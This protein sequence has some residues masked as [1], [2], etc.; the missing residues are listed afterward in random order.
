MHAAQFSARLVAWH[1]AEG[2]HSLP[3]QV[4]RTPYRVWVS[5]IML[6][7][8]QVATVI[9]YFERFMQCFPD[10]F[11]LAA[12]DVDEVLH[13]WSGL[14][15]YARGRNL[16]RAARMLVASHQGEFPED[17]EAVVALPGIGR[18]TAGAILALSRNARHP[19]LD[20]N[21]KRVLTR[22]FAVEGWP[23]S[24]AV[25]K[26]LWVL[27]ETLT[28]AAEAAVYTQAI[29][30][31]GA[32]LCTRGKP[33]CTRCPVA[34]SCLAKA[35]AR[36]GELP[37]PRPRKALPEKST[38][39]LVLSDGDG[40]WLLERRPPRGIWGG[41]WSFPELE[42][43]HEA[44][45]WARMQGLDL[46]GSLRALPPISHTFTHFRLH[47][48]PLQGVVQAS[49]RVLREDAGLCWYSPEA[50]VDIGLAA[51]VSRLLAALVSDGRQRGAPDLR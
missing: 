2:R 44:L 21:V 24:P 26:K 31:L 27:A 19:I 6:Q 16:H 50:P 38:R 35:H 41:L 45:A 30:D 33:L 36:T 29:M 17:I 5:E 47:I 12:A 14:G 28:P 39:F 3:W 23:E 7:Q 9:P 32:M 48:E 11:T 25:Q 43:E 18:S 42:K 4:A 46:H 10:V 8:T 51:P 49:G 40:R 22:H 34:E 20:G 37:T 1:A 15:Y 13:Y